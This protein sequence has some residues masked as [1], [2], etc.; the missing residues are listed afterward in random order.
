MKNNSKI[1]GVLTLPWYNV[2]IDS[3]TMIPNVYHRVGMRVY[4][5]SGYPHGWDEHSTCISKKVKKCEKCE[6]MSNFD[7][8]KGSR[9]SLSILSVNRVLAPTTFSSL[10]LVLYLSKGQD[11]QQTWV[12]FTATVKAFQPVLFLIRVRRPPG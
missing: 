9:V 7:F 8:H 11:N 6:S 4:L 12:A 2:A 1:A 5:I 3:W 10:Q